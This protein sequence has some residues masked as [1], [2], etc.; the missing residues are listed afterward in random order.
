MSLVVLVVS[1]FVLALPFYVRPGG[2][3]TGNEDSNVSWALFVMTSSLAQ[4]GINVSKK[5][6]ANL[7]VVH[8]ASNSRSHQ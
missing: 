5:C 4:Q 2:G 7:K 6:Y 8:C 1:S 3:E